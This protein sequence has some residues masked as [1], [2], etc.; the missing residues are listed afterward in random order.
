MNII[1]CKVL[2][3]IM[4]YRESHVAGMTQFLWR[5]LQLI[6]FFGYVFRKVFKKVVVKNR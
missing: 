6:F 5:I 4:M 3:K 1:L 2:Y